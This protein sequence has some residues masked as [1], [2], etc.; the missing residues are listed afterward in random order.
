MA[1]VWTLVLPSC[2]LGPPLGAESSPGATWCCRCIV[3]AVSGVVG[4]LHKDDFLADG[5]G[6]SSSQL[7]GGFPWLPP[8]QLVA[9]TDLAEGT[10]LLSLGTCFQGA[11]RGAEVGIRASGGRRSP[12]LVGVLRRLW[13]SSH[14][15][16]GHSVHSSTQLLCRTHVA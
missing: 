14:S 2:A 3:P 5:Q 12:A 1:P 11:R 16:Q 15:S 9:T 10:A 6:F 7:S 4:H 13:D 8:H